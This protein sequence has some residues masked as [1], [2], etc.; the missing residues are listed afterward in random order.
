MLRYSVLD[1]HGESRQ[2][3]HPP[4]L[5]KDYD[6]ASN[7]YVR[8]PNYTFIQYDG[9]NTPEIGDFVVWKN[10]D[11]AGAGHIAVVTGLEPAC[12][13]YTK[14]D[15]VEANGYLNGKLSGEVGTDQYDLRPAGVADQYGLILTGW[16]HM[17]TPP[18]SPTPSG[19]SAS[20]GTTAN[21]TQY[22]NMGG[23]VQ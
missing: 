10:S 18:P 8:A 11:P 2:I 9:T 16:L 15:V 7:D 13:P 21:P 22:Y 17:P 4:P 5:A 23:S 6:P 14:V 12:P 3:C 19:P 1:L 20:N